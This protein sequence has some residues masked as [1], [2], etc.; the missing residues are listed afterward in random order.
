[1]TNA[2][3]LALFGVAISV[4]SLGTSVVGW[5]IV[6]HFSSRR[7]LANERRRLRVTYLLEAYRRLESSSNRT[8]MTSHWANFESAIAD[9][10]LL[11]SPRQVAMARQFA[12]AMARDKTASLDELIF[13]LRQSLRTELELEP[14]SDPVVYLRI[15]SQ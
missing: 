12:H 14:V 15:G 10:Q 6:H 8:D 4:L 9:I 13:D 3:I 2:T 7:D 11:G 5:W 1:M